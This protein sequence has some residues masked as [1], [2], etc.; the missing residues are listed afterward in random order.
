MMP[1][2]SFSSMIPFSSGITPIQHHHLCQDNETQPPDVE[3]EQQLK[4]ENTALRRECE[5]L[6]S[7][8]IQMKTEGYVFQARTTLELKTYREKIERAAVAKETLQTQCRELEDRIWNLRDE[9]RSR[10]EEIRDTEKKLRHQHA[11]IE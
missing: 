10:Q 6:E 4:Q 8:V 1:D 11:T 2:A 5:E 7:I 3:D 9:M